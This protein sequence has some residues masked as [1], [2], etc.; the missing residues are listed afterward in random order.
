MI[1][2][3]IHILHKISFHW[4]YTFILILNSL[5]IT[6][7]IVPEI[8]DEYIPYINTGI[9]FILIF[10]IGEIC[11]RLKVEGKKFFKSYRNLYTLFVLA[12]VGVTGRL[13]LTILFLLSSLK[14]LRTIHFI[15]KT[16]HLIEALVHAI[17]GVA[18]LI[19]LICMVFFVFA[20]VG[21]NLFG[22]KVPQ[23]WGTLGQA[24]ISLQQ[25]SLADD[26]G[27][28]MRAT[29]AK[30]PGAWIFFEIFLILMTYI[31]LNVFVAIIVD[32]VQASQEQKPHHASDINQQILKEITA[33]RAQV[34]TFITQTHQ[35]D[36]SV[37]Q[38]K[39]E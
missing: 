37:K 6:V 31:L 22:E 34:T 10:I 12:I 7:K 4:V 18:N 26:W 1:K 30:Y 13:E 11:W 14:A 2:E 32:A 8:S 38:D 39:E 9:I 35:T 29:V 28:G 21:T 17:P 19:I 27:I 24:L 3:E 16:R 33:L 25:M 23:F 20:V 15:P 5:L 36:D